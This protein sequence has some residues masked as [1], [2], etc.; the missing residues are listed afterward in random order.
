MESTFDI[1][2]IIKRNLLTAP[3]TRGLMLSTDWIFV[4]RI[5]VPLLMT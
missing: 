1:I 2:S 4:Q 3:F 5:S